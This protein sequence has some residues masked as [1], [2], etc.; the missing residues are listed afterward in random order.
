MHAEFEEGGGRGKFQM[1]A[2]LGLAIGFACDLQQLSGIVA[3][4]DA[5]QEVFLGKTE[6]AWV[7]GE[8]LAGALDFRGIK[9]AAQE[10]DGIKR[11]GE[12]AIKLFR[13]GDYLAI[14]SRE[15]GELVAPLEVEGPGVAD[16]PAESG[17]GHEFVAAGE[18]DHAVGEG[19]LIGANQFIEAMFDGGEV[20]I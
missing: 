12:A 10:G 20:G 4:G 1:I 14:R 3:V 6:A 18:V 19:E 7:E 11:V 9:L 2:C 8:G 15:P 13:A 16:G 17:G 5:F